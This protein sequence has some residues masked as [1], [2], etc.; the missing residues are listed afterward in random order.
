MEKHLIYLAI[1]FHKFVFKNYLKKI[2]YLFE[3]NIKKDF[4]LFDLGA[5]DGKL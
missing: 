1:K 5:T 2:N 4:T 3:N